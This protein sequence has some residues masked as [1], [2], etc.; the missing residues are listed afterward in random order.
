MSERIRGWGLFVISW[1]LIIIG[2]FLALAAV[3]MALLGF[4]FL[5]PAGPSSRL[6][7]DPDKALREYARLS[8]I[9]MIPLSVGTLALAKLLRRARRQLNSRAKRP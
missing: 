9:W 5:E 6:Q 3:V 8:F 2:L 4:V 1:V 7:L